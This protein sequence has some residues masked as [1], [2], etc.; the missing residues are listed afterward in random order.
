MVFSLFFSKAQSDASCSFP[1]FCLVFHYLYER[2]PL[3]VGGF[4]WLLLGYHYSLSVAAQDK[5][6]WHFYIE[7]YK[8]LLI[9]LFFF[10]SWNAPRLRHNWRVL[11]NFLQSSLFNQYSFNIIHN[12]QHHLTYL[13]HASNQFT[14]ICL[15][16][17]IP[18]FLFL[19]FFYN[20]FNKTYSSFS[21]RTTP[22][23]ISKWSP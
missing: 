16:Q 8:F 23:E 2:H 21:Y 15:F 20:L 9:R 22:I 4:E 5:V 11:T 7:H 3:T 18:K 19:F 14:Q 1:F 10:C 12:S 17:H 13:I 6:T